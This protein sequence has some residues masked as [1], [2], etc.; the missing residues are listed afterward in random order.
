[1]SDTCETVDRGLKCCHGKGHDGPCEWFEVF[2]PRRIALSKDGS[3]P[4]PEPRIIAIADELARAASSALPCKEWDNGVMQDTD[5]ERLEL[6]IKNYRR[7][8]GLK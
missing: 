7:A 2:H 3:M 6:A 5:R 4:M 1:M 8:R